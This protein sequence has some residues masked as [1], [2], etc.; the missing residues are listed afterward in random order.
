MY[1]A[2]GGLP[3]PW[4]TTT[5]FALADANARNFRF[6]NHFLATDEAHSAAR[7]LTILKKYEGLPWVNTIAADST[8]H[9]LYA[10]ILAIPDVTDAEA[11]QVRHRPRP[12][13]VPGGQPAG[14]GWLPPSLRLGHR[15]GLRRPGHLR[16]WRRAQ[17]DEP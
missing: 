10:D 6:L 9:A 1:E 5:A 7:E 13:L 14:A 12:G 4:T 16:S 3:L 15:Q 2:R 8:G 11:A 17:P